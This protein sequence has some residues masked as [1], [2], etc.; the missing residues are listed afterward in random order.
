MTKYYLIAG[1]LVAI[2]ALGVWIDHRSRSATRHEEPAPTELAIYAPGRVEGASAEVELRPQ[3]HGRVSAVRVREGDH[4]ASGNVLFELVDDQYR[5]EAALATAEVA[6]A[7][8]ALARLLSGAR[9]EELDEAAAV[10]Q[11]KSA[12]LERA[13]LT[14][15]RTRDLGA[16]GVVSRQETDDQRMQVASLTAQLA[17]A[18]AR[19]DLLNAPPRSEDVDEAQAR[20]D[21]VEAKY[22]LA[23]VEWEHTRVRSAAGGQILAVNVEPGELAAPDSVEAAIVMADT[24]RLRVRAFVEEMD[25]PRVV[26]AMPVEVTADGLEG[27]TFSGRVSRLSPRMSRKQLWSD[28]PAERLDTKVREVWIDLD[29]SQDA[30]AL[31]VGLPVEVTIRVEQ[32]ETQQ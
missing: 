17:A 9:R 12:E 21:A 8:A 28:A 2:A 26:V 14:W 29:K 31:V 22:Q 18:A 3:L 23:I 15:E 27:H 13:R 19:R 6:S 4:V 16:E 7:K 5:H 25:A 1:G 11:T 32:A 24:S 30:S 10:Y 20:V